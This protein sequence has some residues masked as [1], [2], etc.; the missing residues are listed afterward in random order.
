[1][2]RKSTPLAGEV[3]I[4]ISQSWPL[5]QRLRT[6]RRHDIGAGER[7]GWCFAGG[8]GPKINEVTWSSA[9]ITDALSL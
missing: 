4:V 2:N 8:P 9:R 5:S 7:V 6:E 1:M 3:E